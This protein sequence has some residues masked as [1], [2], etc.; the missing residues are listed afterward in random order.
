MANASVARGGRLDRQ[1][2]FRESLLSSPSCS[3]YAR[4]SNKLTDR[5]E[6][7]WDE[8]APWGVRVHVAVAL[9]RT[10]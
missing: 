2:L 6:R 1:E 3:C 8:Y 10:R 7:A 9:F 4:L 5:Q